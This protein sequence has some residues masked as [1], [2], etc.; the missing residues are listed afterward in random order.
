MLAGWNVRAR[1]ST[2]R[3]PGPS[4]K[5]AATSRTE[6][7]AVHAPLKIRMSLF[8]VFNFGGAQI[9]VFWLFS[10]PKES[11]ACRK[12]AF[13]L[14]FSP[15]SPAT[16]FLRETSPRSEDCQDTHVFHADATIHDCR[17]DA[18]IPITVSEQPR[19]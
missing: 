18:A 16:Y 5:G 17:S 9:H 13:G 3:A 4:L 14:F 15:Q 12:F 6:S 19:V 1:G 8:G 2:R 10:R 7:M 11:S